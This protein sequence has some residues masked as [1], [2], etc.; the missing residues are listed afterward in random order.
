MKIGFSS[1]VCPTWDLPTIVSK[2]AEYKYDGVE[3]RGLQGELRLTMVPALAGNPGATRSL[4]SSAG[5]ELLCLSTSCS[6][7]SRDRKVIARHRAELD[8]HIELA[9]K[10]GCPFVRIFVGDV[11]KGEARENTL[12][13]VAAELTRI[14][15][16]AAEHRVAVLVT[17]SG[18]F[19]GSA[20]L[21]YLIDCVS[22]P[23][24][25]ACWDPCAAMTIRERPTTSIPRLGGKIGMVHICDAEFDDRGFM[26]GGY[27]VPGTGD[28]ELERMIDLLKGTL[29]TDYLVFEWPKLWEP[30]LAPPDKVLPE[31]VAFLRE[32]LAAKDAILSAYKGK[33]KKGPTFKPM[34]PMSAAR[35]G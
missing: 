30:T 3:L 10:L 25:S 17:N 31:A 34:P 20:D 7:S 13:R 12:S 6:F 16:F 8:E 11:Q 4:F 35:P 32:R 2:A 23:A 29:Y 15:A 1:L 9:A 26:S 24:I 19:A 22:H 5:V 33:D 27:K 14:A 18:D 21:W 28:V